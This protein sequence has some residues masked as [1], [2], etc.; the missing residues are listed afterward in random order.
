M[1]KCTRKRTEETSGEHH[2]TE[3]QYSNSDAKNNTS[4]TPITY[5]SFLPMSDTKTMEDGLMNQTF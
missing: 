1:A 2:L 4:K 5:T 3:W